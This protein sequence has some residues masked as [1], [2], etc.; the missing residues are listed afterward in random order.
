M[1]NPSSY[2]K[3]SLITASTISSVET[4]RSLQPFPNHTYPGKNYFQIPAEWLNS[5]FTKCHTKT[6]S[7]KSAPLS[8]FIL[9]QCCS[10]S[11]SEEMQFASTIQPVPFIL[12]CKHAKPRDFPPSAIRIQ[13]RQKEEHHD[14]PIVPWPDKGAQSTWTACINIILGTEKLCFILDGKLAVP[15]PRRYSSTL[16]MI[17]QH[18]RVGQVLKSTG[19]NRK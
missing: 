14:N 3:F 8:N 1:A 15:I 17:P 12:L 13:W 18:Y 11:S 4:A 19:K 5:S 16:V 2:S 10:I 6:P 7:L 9:S